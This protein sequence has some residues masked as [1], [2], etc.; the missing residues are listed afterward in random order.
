MAAGPLR[1]LDV[2]EA[3]VHFAPLLSPFRSFQLRKPPFIQLVRRVR[4][5]TG[6]GC[7]KIE[8]AISFGSY[9]C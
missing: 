6:S 2:L 7:P 5:Q 4:T 9:Y 1:P 8:K 3:D